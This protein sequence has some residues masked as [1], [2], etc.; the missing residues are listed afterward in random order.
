MQTVSFG[1]SKHKAAAQVTQKAA[2]KLIN[3]STTA[4]AKHAEKHAKQQAADTFVKG[5]SKKH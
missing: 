2:S 5:S 3:S 1:G 4:P